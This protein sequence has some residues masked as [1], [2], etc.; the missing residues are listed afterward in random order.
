M[1]GDNR[2]MTAVGLIGWCKRALLLA[3]I[4]APALVATTPPVAA[5]TSPFANLPGRWTGEGMLG[6]KDSPTEKVKCRATYFL[7]EGKDE[8][9][10]NIRCAT[11]GGSVE[12]KSEITHAAGELSGTWQ[13]TTRNIGGDL[14]GKVTPLGF[15]ITVKS[16]D[17]TANMDIVVKGNKQ[18]VEVQ[19]INSSMIGLTLLLTKG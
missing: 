12:I 15:R 17:I 9:K 16:Q 6:L 8:L 1:R 2:V 19:F 11:S 3:L 18:I 7:T 10:Q 5:D 4:C 14:T 13:E